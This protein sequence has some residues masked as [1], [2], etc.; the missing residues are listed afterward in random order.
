M[1]IARPVVKTTKIVLA[2]DKKRTI[3]RPFLPREASKIKNIISRVMSLSPARSERHLAQLLKEFSRRHDDIKSV[4]EEH[5]EMVSLYLPADPKLSEEIR[6]LIG[7]YFTSEYTFESVALFNPSIVLHPD[8]SGL[9]E[10]SVR[11]VMSL[12]ATGEGH[13][14]SL[15]FR[16]GVIDSQGSIFIDGHGEYA[17]TAKQI[18]NTIYDKKSFAMKLS[19][20]GL[21]NNFSLNVMNQ[22][23]DSFTFLELSNC[24]KNTGLATQDAQLQGDTFTSDKIMW[25]ALSNYETEFPSGR[26]MSDFVI[27]PNSPAEQNGIEDARFVL[28]R[29]DDGSKTYYATYTAYDGRAILSQLLETKDFYHFKMI[30]LN[31]KAVRNKGMALFPRKINGKYVMI[32]RQDN[33]NLSI[34]Y[35]DDLHFWHEYSRIMEPSYDWEFVQIGNCGSPIETDKGW[36]VLT[37]GVGP[38]RK[39]CIGATLL[40]LN[41][42]AKV[43]GR[44]KKPLIAPT[45]CSGKGYVPNVVYSCGAMIHNGK[46]IFPYAMSDS[47]TTI[48]T[49]DMKKLLDALLV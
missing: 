4:L 40:D 31:G 7:C 17:I 14:S 27:F 15:T 28:F 12:R 9:P 11:F 18:K 13:V 5:Y 8:Q 44:L 37:H 6:L 39:Y 19:E 43:I 30:T 26:S 47:F 38:M 49:I 33:E 23:K 2:P 34:M 1:K 3:L 21:K 10:G 22:M 36:L 32:S 42:P 25:L 24:V 35:S 29:D 46:L 41:D 48:A 20:I 16:T 45:K